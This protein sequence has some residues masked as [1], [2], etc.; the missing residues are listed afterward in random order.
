MFVPSFTARRLEPCITAPTVSVITPVRIA[1]SNCARAI[2]TL[3]HPRAI[4][5]S[6]GIKLRNESVFWF[7]VC[8]ILTY[9]E[10]P[11]YTGALVAA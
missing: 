10:W 6:A 8:W 5:K 4:Q 9:S 1:D 2:P 11:R 3:N 7:F